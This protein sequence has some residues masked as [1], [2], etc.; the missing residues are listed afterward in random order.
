MQYNRSIMK[1]SVYLLIAALTLICACHPEDKDP[2]GPSIVNPGDIIVNGKE[3]LEPDQQKQKLEQ[4]A[5]KV[6]NLLPASEFE[7]VMDICA[8]ALG[9]G[10]VTFEEGY[11]ISE[12][13]GVWEDM[14]E[15]F[16]SYQEISDTEVRIFLY[17]FF[18][19][20][21]GVVEFGE[22]KATYKKSSETKVIYYEED[23]TKWEVE[24]TPKKLKE[25]Y[26]GE[27]LDSYYDYED[28]WSKKYYNVTV[29]V[30]GSL[31]AS[32]KRNGN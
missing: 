24:I 12:L 2:K 13:E 32:I 30:P 22:H 26:L 3:T 29:E 28:V 23:G 11:D 18:S 15:D 31:S 4:V 25:V 6:L 20:C 17:L 1:K 10:A 5:T 27:W 16:F 21:T 19:N 14:E 7:D 9:D 8:K